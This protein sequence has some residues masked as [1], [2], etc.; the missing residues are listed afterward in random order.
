MDQFASMRDMRQLQ[1]R[2]RS[3]DNEVRE[4]REYAAHRERETRFWQEQAENC[5]EDAA[6]WEKNFKKLS[7]TNADLQKRLDS[8]E[9]DLKTKQAEVEHHR[10]QNAPLRKDLNNT[11]RQLE[12]CKSAFG[13]VQSKMT[14]QL[15]GNWPQDEDQ[16]VQQLI[17]GF[18]RSLRVWAKKYA[19]ASFDAL[20][21]LSEGHA[22]LMVEISGRVAY[23]NGLEPL[24][25]LK[26][27]FLIL[28][29]LVSED[30]RLQIF[31]NPFFIFRDPYDTGIGIDQ[32]L[33]SFYE[34]MME[35]K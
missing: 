35:S 33:Y 3:L 1:R 17:N 25:T 20:L 8:K 16:R 19:A 28:T 14:Q 11:R 2:L 22:Q 13:N 24:T 23:V 27:P 26:S 34:H 31:N 10:R 7:S 30:I 32:K 4:L 6:Y 18:Y 9:Q 5:D 21:M 29:A 15:H 12:S